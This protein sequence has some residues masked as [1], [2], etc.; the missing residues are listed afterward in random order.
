[1][2]AGGRFLASGLIDVD[3]H[4]LPDIGHEPFIEAPELIFPT[5]IRFLAA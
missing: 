1:M 2:V 3:V 4:V 5:I